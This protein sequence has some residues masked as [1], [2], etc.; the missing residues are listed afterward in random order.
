MHF[1]DGQELHE[2]PSL[3]TGN[4]D[5]GAGC[6]LRSP[7]GAAAPVQKK[8]SPKKEEKQYAHD[9]KKAIEESEKI[10]RLQMTTRSD[11]LSPEDSTSSSPITGPAGIPTP[12]HHDGSMGEVATHLD[13]DT[14]EQPTSDQVPT[15]R[16]GILSFEPQPQTDE[17]LLDPSTAQ[18][19]R[20]QQLMDEVRRNEEHRDYYN[21][22][23]AILQPEEDDVILNVDNWEDIM[24]EVGWTAAP[25]DT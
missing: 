14:S 21:T 1:L 13:P 2:F 20:H 4:G 9:F 16:L 8:L 15:T 22:D 25:A 17:P 5:N 11:A 12:T 3:P 19:I 18:R 10:N 7:S 24:I 6:A 23:L